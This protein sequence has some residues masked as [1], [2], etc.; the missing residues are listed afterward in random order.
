MH[1]AVAS[2][3]RHWR[4]PILRVASGACID[5]LP[6]MQW[7][8]LGV[9]TGASGGTQQISQVSPPTQELRRQFSPDFC[10]ARTDILTYFPAYR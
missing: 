6:G 5:G 3:K 2:H 9:F 4:L 10:V 8:I 7:L 1:F